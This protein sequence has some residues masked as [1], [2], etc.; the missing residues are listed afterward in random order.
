MLR[1]PGVTAEPR[2]LAYPRLQL[3]AVGVSGQASAL[4]VADASRIVLAA[5]RVA[6]TIVRRRNV[7]LR[8]G[9]AAD[10]PLPGILNLPKTM[11]RN[12]SRWSSRLGM[13]VADVKRLT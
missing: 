4:A 12:Q 3:S 5:S 13:P 2:D 1:P 8:A 10:D 9:L 6:R 11:A 7:R